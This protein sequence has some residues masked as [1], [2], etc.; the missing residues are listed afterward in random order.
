MSRS[1]QNQGNQKA[2]GPVAYCEGHKHQYFLEAGAT[3]R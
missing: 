2:S 1:I 3:I